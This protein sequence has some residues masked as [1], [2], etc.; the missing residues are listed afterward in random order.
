MGYYKKTDVA[1]ILRRSKPNNVVKVQESWSSYSA[2]I[3]FNGLCSKT[4]TDTLIQ[5]KQKV[6]DVEKE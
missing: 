2:V 1:K 5:K 4:G 6:H 3:A